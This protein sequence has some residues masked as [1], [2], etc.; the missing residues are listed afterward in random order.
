MRGVKA[1]AIAWHEY[2]GSRTEISAAESAQPMFVTGIGTATPRQSYS[3]AQCWHAFQASDWYRR[4]APRSHAI[5]QNVL[6]HDNGIESRHLALASLDE[7][8]AIDPDTLARRFAIHAPLLASEAGDHAVSMAGIAASQIDAIIVST[9]TGY[10]CPGL[11]GYV[12]E[13]LGL[14]DDVQA[15]DLVGQGCGAAL[16]NLGMADALLSSAQCRHVLS[17]CVEVCSAAMYLDDDPG[18]LI[19]ACLFGDGAGAAVLSRQPAGHGRRIE[20]KRSR[21]LTNTAQRHAL[22]FGQ[23]GGMLRNVLTRQVPHLAAEHAYRLLQATLDEAG[24]AQDAIRAWIMHAG[25][26]DVLHALQRK[27]G[28]APQDLH[29]SADM[30]RRYGNL[31]S[32]FVYFVLQAA[33]DDDAASGWWWMSSF[34]AGFSCHGALLA[35]EDSLSSLP[36]SVYPETLDRLAADDPRAQR[37]RSDLRRLNR[38][39][40]TRAIILRQLKRSIAAPRRIIELGAGDGT[41]MLE[42]AGL[43]APDWPNAHLTLLDRQNLVTAQTASAFGALGWQVEILVM[44]VLAWLA[45]PVRERYSLTL[46]NL[47]MHHFDQPQLA[48]ML[49]AIAQRTDGFFICEPKRGWLPLAA[50]HLVGLIGANAVTRQDAVLSVHAGFAGKDLS[51]LWP[52]Q[53]SAWRL[54]EYSAG[55]FSHCFLALRCGDGARQP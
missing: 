17:V 39:M 5:V 32:A 35:V 37:S 6:L 40:G 11:S 10:L 3:K 28:L 2:S 38:I 46:A 13:K 18:V 25:G 30:L 15:Y 29:Y 47:F 12:I 52:A 14:R 26:R 50:S 36:R 49:A 51:A 27:F 55:W 33:L 42:L 53:A 20:W 48:T 54:S 19:S 24:I 43:L 7:V 1:Q 31:S 8:F 45:Q 21:S 4:L 44:D 41:L 9:C 22:Y 16:P 23:S 34:G